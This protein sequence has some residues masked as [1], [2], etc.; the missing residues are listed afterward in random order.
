VCATNP[1]RRAKRPRPSLKPIHTKV[2]NAALSP[3][4]HLNSKLSNSTRQTIAWASVG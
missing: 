2:L 4:V 1:S 3:L